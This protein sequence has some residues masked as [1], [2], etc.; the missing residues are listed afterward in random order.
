MVYK[1]LYK[2]LV[3]NGIL[4][5]SQYGFRHNHSTVHAVTEFI[6]KVIKCFEKGELT[7]GI[8]LDLSKAFDTISHEIVLEKMERY[9]VR[10]IAL[11]WFKSYLKDQEHYV[12]FNGSCSNKQKVEIGVPQGS[13]LGP[14]L[15]LIYTNDLHK[16]LKSSSSIIFTDD[17]TVYSTGKDIELLFDNLKEDMSY[18]INWFKANK[19]SLNLSK[20]NYILSLIH[21]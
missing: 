18:L 8:F 10:G 16:C 14:L 3:K 15:F 21:I 19:L 1:R 7:L 17:T 9:G 13:V 20:T 11:K 4:Y 5:D 12:K 2:F 6:E